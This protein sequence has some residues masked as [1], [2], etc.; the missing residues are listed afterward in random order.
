MYRLDPSA[1][2]RRA[3]RGYATSVCVNQLVQTME[4]TGQEDLLA[5][6][7]VLQKRLK[8]ASAPT[9]HSNMYV[10]PHHYS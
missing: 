3:H 7:A 2:W 1:N 10:A 9:M 5:F 4:I 8:S 6:W